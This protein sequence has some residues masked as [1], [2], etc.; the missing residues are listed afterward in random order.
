MAPAIP[1][2]C[3]QGKLLM[4]TSFDVRGGLQ[5][6]TQIFI[7]LGF[8]RSGKIFDAGMQRFLTADA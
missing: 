3:I 4:L 2:L 5:L 7:R 8:I 1:G 6:G